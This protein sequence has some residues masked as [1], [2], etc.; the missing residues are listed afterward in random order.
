MNRRNLQQFIQELR[1][2][3]E[4]REARI[5]RFEKEWKAIN[6]TIVQQEA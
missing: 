4:K 2:S 6:K 3:I 1:I 5:A